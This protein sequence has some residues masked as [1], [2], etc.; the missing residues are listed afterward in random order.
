[1]LTI[2]GIQGLGLIIDFIDKETESELLA[3]IDTAEWD[4]TLSRR[5][6]QYGFMYSYTRSSK[7]FSKK[8]AKI[9]PSMTG[10]IEMIR[11]RIMESLECNLNQCIVN[12]YTRKQGIA[13]HIDN[14]SFGKVVVSLSLNEGCNFIMTNIETGVKVRLWIPR[15]SLLIMTEDARYLWSHSVSSNIGMYIDTD[16]YITDSSST[17][18]KRDANWRRISVTFRTLE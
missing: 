7:G 17:Q 18:V 4:T 16:T 2:D 14:L 8:N 9:A 3:Q 15:R 13:P 5:V 6:Q 11:T 10:A 1:M 12:E